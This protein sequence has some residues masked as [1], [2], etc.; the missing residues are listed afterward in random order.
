MKFNLKLTYENCDKSEIVKDEVE[1][2]LSNQ[3][4]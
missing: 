3:I 1:I 2:G 4:G